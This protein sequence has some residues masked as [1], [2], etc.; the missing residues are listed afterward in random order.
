MA[1]QG[2]GSADTTKPTK[3]PITDEDVD[4]TRA[5]TGLFVVVGGDVAIVVAVV[6][7]LVRFANARVSGNNAVL[8]S[9]LSSAF[10]AVATMTTAYFGIRATSN[11][12][13]RSIK[14]PPGERASASSA[15][16]TSTGTAS[17]AATAGSTGS[18]GSNT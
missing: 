11:T 18:T 17:G 2:T 15:G 12:A 5:W 7:A 10:A 1:D 9:L 13:Q 3:L 16:T 4:K 6:I 14:H 8:A